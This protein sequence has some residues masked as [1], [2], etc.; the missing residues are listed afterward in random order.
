MKIP[1]LMKKNLEINKKSM[2]F[3]FLTPSKSAEKV[4]VYMNSLN[5]ALQEEDVKNI[6]ISG[7][8]GAGK[9]SFIITF[10]DKNPQYNFLDVS[11]ATF[12]KEDKDL[13]LIEKSI[14]QQIFYKVEQKEIPFSRFK[15][16]SKINYLK[17]KTIL[18]LLFII[19]LLVFFDSKYFSNSFTNNLLVEIISVFIL[20][21]S[22]FV[23]TKSIIKNFTGI[24]LDKLNLQNLEITTNKENEN[25]LLNKYL[26]EIIYFFSET[27][28]NVVVFQDLDRF[29]NVQIFTKLRELNTF[30]NNSEQLKCKHKKIV[31]VYAVKDEMFQN[32]DNS[33]SDDSRTKFFDFMIPIIPYVNSST[34]YDK[35]LEFFDKDLKDKEKF[36]N[37]EARDKFKEFL[38]DISLD[39]KD[40]RLLKNIYNEYKIYDNQL[41]NLDRVKLLAIMV[42]KNFYPKDFSLLHKDEGAVFS[43]FK[44]RSVYIKDID[45]KFTK[46]VEDIQ[47]EIKQIENEQISSVEELR[48]IYL[49]T[50]ISKIPNN[51]QYLRVDN[52]NINFN[53]AINNN[54][55]NTIKNSNEIRHPNYGNGIN[56]KNIEKELNDE[57]TYDEREKFIHSKAD[58][59][60]N[61]LNKKIKDIN[62]KQKTLY[63]KNIHQLCE[64]VEVKNRINKE[65]TEQ[66]LKN[67]DLL[68]S[69]VFNGHIDENYY[70][71]LSYSFNKSL[72]PSDT[73]FLKSI[74]NNNE[75]DYS[76]TLTNLDE[77][78]KKIKINE[79]R[80][81]SILNY[82]LIEF[83]VKN[84]NSLTNQYQE[85]FKQLSDNSEKSIDFILSYL[86][87]LP[88]YNKF[89]VEITKNWIVFWKFIY[90]N[91]DLTIEQKEELFYQLFFNLS[92]EQLMSLNIDNSLKEYIENFTKLRDLVDEDNRKMKELISSLDIRFY[93]LSEPISNIPLFAHIYDNNLYK[94]NRLM[95]EQIISSLY[96][97]KEYSEELLYSK[98]LS[99]IRNLDID[100]KLVERIEKNITLY[101][102]DIFLVIETNRNETEET[103]IWLLNNENL[104]NEDK[105]KILD[106][107][108]TIIEDISEIKNIEILEILFEKN[109]IKTTWDNLNSFYKISQSLT[110][111]IIEYLN[112]IEN[113]TILSKAR[114]DSIYIKNEKDIDK[115]LLKSILESNDI[116]DESYGLLIKLIGFRFEHL[117]ICEVGENKIDLI[118]KHNKIAFNR[119]NIENLISC[120]ISK[121]IILIENYFDEFIE[122]FDELSD[123]F[124][125]KD[126]IK[127][128]GS[129]NL[130][131]EEK[132]TLIALLNIESFEINEEVSSLL[133]QIYMEKKEA[134]SYLLLDKIISNLPQSDKLKI[135]VEQ[136]E[137]NNFEFNEISNLLEKL[138]YPYNKLCLK[139]GSYE[140][141][142]NTGNNL[143]LVH[144]L[145]QKRCISSFSE[146]GRTIRVNRF[147]G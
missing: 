35:L 119:D 120:S 42:Y 110:K 76:Y 75:L 70:M 114:I 106:S 78:V 18:V 53:V 51:P 47:K 99:T 112:N 102:N 21:V 38:R 141:I 107:Q 124:E 135:L 11:L 54:E 111:S 117:N 144:F 101:I 127:L 134:I 100:K 17:T 97:S 104:I 98:H 48:K 84:K 24:T 10:E 8:Y 5:E 13:S 36:I 15:R 116:T 52:K 146:K 122:T 37:E 60:R 40:M 77:L 49:Y 125:E 65:L 138:S 130:N 89:I 115:E 50:I 46:E 96:S 82:N 9:S 43:I 29:E 88:E 81:Q 143:R 105:Y 45:S 145:R 72:T 133:F 86:D 27:K 68:S 128:L 57:F 92:V 26:D 19:S 142:P 4:E 85:V 6:A 90:I 93:N 69:L 87:Y 118:L 23:F 41:T 126:F 59:T 22:G 32:D 63:T 83:I 136:L 16:I 3:Q 31:F 132:F 95:I 20:I 73:E 34:S 108:D 30:L 131:I 39:I 1:F 80:K 62:N 58:E 61:K 25:S 12:K 56:F 28:Y 55:F 91:D 147:K 71:F 94:L 139:V 74:I 2:N 113:A 129:S 67:K 109:K 64:N 44:N 33:T 14:L 137:Y 121:H 66:N 103:L 7:S 123:L 79:Y 140:K